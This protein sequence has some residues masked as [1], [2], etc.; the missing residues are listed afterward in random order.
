MAEPEEGGETA[1]PNGEPTAEAVAARVAAQ[2]AR[3]ELSDCAWRGGGGG[4]RLAAASGDRR[5]FAVKP[6]LGDAVLFFSYDADDDG[7]YDGADGEPREHARELPDDA[8]REVD[9][10]E[11]D[12]RARVRDGDVGDA[13]GAFSLTLH[14]SPYDRVGAARAVP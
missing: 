3:G 7:A 8:R 11:V 2:R 6:R 5:G 12:P 14:Q 4:R 13:R 1:F 9:R 10:D